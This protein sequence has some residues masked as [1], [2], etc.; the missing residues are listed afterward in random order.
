MP[1]PFPVIQG[2]SGGGS[3]DVVAA[4]N[5]SDLTDASAA[6][7]N[8]GLGDIAV[9]DVVTLTQAAYDALSPPD[10]NTIYLIES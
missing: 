7:D 2:A 6:R 9:K 3:G 5:L 10:A 4:N 1:S 8:L